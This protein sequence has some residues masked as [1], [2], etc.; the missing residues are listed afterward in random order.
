MWM[1]NSF[2]RKILNVIFPPRC[3]V[4]KQ[5]DKTI[6]D[7]CLNKF[8]QS[9]DSPLIYA[10]SIYSF[11]DNNVRKIIHAIK[12]YHRHDLIEPLSQK[13]AEEVK[14]IIINNPLNT[15]WILVPIPMSK[16]RKYMR[17]Y[18]QAELIA[19][20]ISKKTSIIIRNDILIRIRNTKRQ[21]KSNNRSERLRNQHNS[22]KVVNNVTDL[23]IILVDDVVTT[24][25]TINEA[26]N[27][28][29]KSLANKVI[30]VS[31]VH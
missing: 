10:K 13:L 19:K 29:K 21:V 8:K 6:C 5:D 31:I 17:G 4:C 9:I 27:A 18:N 15:N 1:I 3:Y 12:Y 26:R 7:T 22:F 20:E 28:L 2:F 25:A 23:N 14:N 30:A 16:I 24:G 11:K